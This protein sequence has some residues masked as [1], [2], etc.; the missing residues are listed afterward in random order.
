M[1]PRSRTTRQRGGGV[2]RSAALTEA[3]YIWE[4]RGRGWDVYPEPVDLEPPFR[5]FV[6]HGVPREQAGRVR[7]D[8][9]KH[10]VLSSIAEAVKSAVVP[11]SGDGNAPAGELP[12]DGEPE[13]Q[14]FNDTAPVSAMQLVL[15]E[16]LSVTPALAESLLLSFPR[17]PRPIAFE[18]VGSVDRV[19]VQL[20]ARAPDVPDVRRQVRAHLPEAHIEDPE[21]RLADQWRR[22]GE[23]VVIDFGLSQEFMR[24]LRTPTSFDTDP[25]SGVI[26]ALAELESGELGVLQVLFQPVRHQWAASVLRA[27]RPALGG[28]RSGNEFVRILRRASRQSFFADAPEMPRLARAKVEH[29]LFAVVIRVGARA[30]SERRAWKIA[31]AVGGPLTRLSRPDSNE[32]I[33]LENRNYPEEDHEEDLLERR[34]RRP[35]MLLNSEELTAIAHPPSK[36]VQS[37]KLARTRRTTR[38]VPE[39]ADGHELVLGLN[40]H[41]GRTTEVTLGEHQRLRHMHLV[42]A[43][44]TGK[45]HLLANLAIQDLNAGRGFAML[46]PHGDLVDLVM[47]HVPDERLSDVVLVDVADSEHPVGFNVLR[48]HSDLEETLLASDL[49]AVFRRLSTSWGDRMDS[50]LRNAVLAFVDSETPGTL[51]DLKRFLVEEGFRHRIL[52][53][54]TDAQVRYYWEREFPQ[55]RGKPHTPLLTRLDQ[56]LAPKPVRYMVC[57]VERTLDLGAAMREGRIVLV[58]LAQGAIGEEN[59]ALLGAL[60]VAKFHQLALARQRLREEDR[61]PFYLYIDEFQHFVTPSMAQVLS[62]ARKY[63][64]GLLLAHQELEQ[65]KARSP[66]VASAVLTHAYTRV[67]FRAGAHDARTLAQGLAHFDPGDLQKLSVGEAVCRME[68][69]DWDFNLQT[70]P[71]PAVDEA[72]AAERRER[73]REIARRRYA[74]PRVEVEAALQISREGPERTAD[75]ETEAVTGVGPDAPQTEHPALAEAAGASS[76]EREASDT[77]VQ[78]DATPPAGDPPA[79]RG[80]GGAIHRKIQLKL[81]RSGEEFGYKSTI[82]KQVLEGGGHVD[83]ALE[84]NGDRLA[85][86]VS[87]SSTPDRELANIRK[88]RKAGFDDVL[89]FA[90]DADALN[91]LQDG[92]EPVLSDDERE[93]VTFLVPER[94]TRFLEERDAHARSGEQRVKG[95]KVN[96]EYKTVNERDKKTFTDTISKVMTRAMRRLSGDGS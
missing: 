75:G 14:P 10:T 8:A 11:S 28:G 57:Q 20:A 52:R 45:S 80:R 93:S 48:A 21:D 9:R 74:T 78:E 47:G 46:D 27:V 65:L 39:V 15:P 73:I 91:T 1:A 86:E 2:S 62:E 70:D 25:L 87:V 94:F 31:R 13:P 81:K 77:R 64:L 71:L 82:E 54:V 38:S 96:V 44:G 26:G 59:A 7:D 85:C 92:I 79:P 95:Y 22:P 88:C 55:M 66:T 50:V 16:Q 4:R 49:T 69:A 33:P 60:L 36:T 84:R 76:T 37:A 83:V 43:T 3:F 19:A 30:D 68:R 40:T 56:F 61:R 24:P 63:R 51:F 34:S 6:F 17:I 18:V 41:A 89:L 58:R 12:W 29:P 90:P 42:G 23:S 35:G 5:P 32:L 72:V 67:V 53:T